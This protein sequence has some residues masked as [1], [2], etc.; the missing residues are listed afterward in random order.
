MNEWFPEQYAAAHRANV[1]TFYGFAN[2]AFDGFQKLIELNLQTA[3]TT[4]ADAQAALLT[5]DPQELVA[6]QSAR[7]TVVA[8]RIQSYNRR[9]YDI[10]LATQTG[11]ATIAG[12]RFETYNQRMQ[13]LVEQVSKQAPAGSEAAV[14]A[15]KKV[16]DSSNALYDSV[17]KS[18]RQAV[19]MAE[20]SL[21]AVLPRT[22]D[23]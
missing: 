18:V 22:S 21:D 9:V 14:V 17:N 15:L 8:E 7:T 10:A 2:Q 6:R 23:A 1:E 3:K 11:F 5:T 4:L 13:A 20:G 19:H 12:A 16:I